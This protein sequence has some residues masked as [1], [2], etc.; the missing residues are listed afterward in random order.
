MAANDS[1]DLYQMCLTYTE[2]NV[3]SFNSSTVGVFQRQGMEAF[4]SHLDPVY[5]SLGTCSFPSGGS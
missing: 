2:V 1:V 5:D 4:L 3:F